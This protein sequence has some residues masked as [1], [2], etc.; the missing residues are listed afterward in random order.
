[1]KKRKHIVILLLMISSMM[2]LIILQALWLVNSYEKAFYDLRR[3]ANDIF[4][5][6][7]YTMRDSLISKNILAVSTDSVHASLPA[8]PASVVA[9]GTTQRVDSA[10]WEE[11]AGGTVARDE[12]VRIYITSQDH[13]DSVS[14]DMLKPVVSR[15]QS[16]QMRGKRGAKSFVVRL[17]ADTLDRDSLRHEF[18]KA[19]ANASFNLPFEIYH[20]VR[21]PPADRPDFFSDFA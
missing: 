8:M 14:R 10:R 17:G 21:T 9:Y 19:L 6:T 18:G 2:L 20:I 13:V 11:A 7:V 5:S 16:F 12:K 3:E 1:M 15:I 4:R